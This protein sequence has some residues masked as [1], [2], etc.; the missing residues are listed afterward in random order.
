MR[1]N[2]PQGRRAGNAAAR[3]GQWQAAAPGPSARFVRWQAMR[4]ILLPLSCCLLAIG[5]A[6]TVPPPS[7][8]DAA[9]DA[10]SSRMLVGEWRVAGID[11]EDFDEPYAIALSA[12]DSE[13]WW[14][15][16]CAR[17]SV[18]YSI[19]GSRFRPIPPAGSPEEPVA[20]CAIAV[21]PRLPDV[22]D[23]IRMADSIERTSA[24]G[25]RLSGN[26]RSLTLFSQ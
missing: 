17:Q 6:G 26:G 10:A 14:N 12:S 4:R 20:V 3:G 21:P 5:C 1:G 15:P 2:L 24:N 19:E 11:G 8:P 9:Q 13:I 25:I 7:Q 23:S 16:R 18:R 22:I